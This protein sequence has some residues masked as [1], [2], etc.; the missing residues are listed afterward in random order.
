MLKDTLLVT[1][2]ALLTTLAL[3]AQ[4]NQRANNSQ[5][6]ARNGN[7]AI[8]ASA[9]EKHDGCDNDKGKLTADSPH[10]YTALKR[11]EWWVVIVAALT[12]GVIGWQ[13]WETRKAAQATETNVEA[14]KDT[15]KR[16]LRAYMSIKNAKLLLHDDGSVEASLELDNCGQTPAYDLQGAHL[17]R[18][19]SYPVTNPGVPPEGTRKSNSIIGAGK[20]FF[21]LANAIKYRGMGREE[22]LASLGLPDFVCCINGYFTYRDIFK[23]PHYLKFQMIVGG[24]AGIRQDRDKD[25]RLF[26]SFSNDSE[27]N[28]AD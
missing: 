14:G 17:C 9:P 23:D 24:P 27:G 28:E 4:P 20:Q 3:S 1:V 11:P 5:Q 22:L 15:A 25:G 21:A 8:V 13:S 19:D 16:Q 26:A 10:W 18:F 7:V 2:S 12:G 6:A